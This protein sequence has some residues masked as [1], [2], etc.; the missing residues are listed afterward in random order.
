MDNALSQRRDHR[1]AHLPRRSGGG[2]L[3]T[4]VPQRRRPRSLQ[5]PA[6]S[7]G[8]TARG[9]TSAR[10]DCQAS[11]R[12]RKRFDRIKDNLW[13]NYVE[14]A[15]GNQERQ[16]GDVAGRAAETI[17]ADR[18]RRTAGNQR[19]EGRSDG[20]SRVGHDARRPRHYRPKV[21]RVGRRSRKTRTATAR[22]ATS[23]TPRS[24]TR[25]STS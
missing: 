3:Q 7:F 12:P 21:D 22:F 8:S 15:G 19:R 18:T 5:L 17:R 25:T 16:A 20:P 2:D 23:S 4:E 24:G 1:G 11:K 6:P 14:G 9:R 10:T 13:K